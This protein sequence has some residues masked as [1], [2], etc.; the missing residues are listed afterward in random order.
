MSEAL[1]LVFSVQE[2]IC[3]P[4]PAGTFADFFP[5]LGWLLTL[6]WLPTHDQRD[7]G[8]PVKEPLTAT[9]LDFTPRRCT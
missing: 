5:C 7:D 3:V 8:F 1:I 6:A 2:D 4:S 9:L